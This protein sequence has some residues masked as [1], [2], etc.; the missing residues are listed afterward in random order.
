L[1]G[2]IFEPEAGMALERTL[3]AA[4]DAMLAAGEVEAVRS[5]HDRLAEIGGSGDVQRSFD[6]AAALVAAGE[7]ERAW[8]ELERLGGDL[9]DS[10]LLELHRRRAD[11]A[12]ARGDDAESTAQLRRA[13]ELAEKS[14]DRA[15][16]AQLELRLSLADFSAGDEATASRH[17]VSALSNWQQAGAFDPL[18][19]MVEEL[20]G[21]TST[22]SRGWTAALAAIRD[23]VRELDDR[24]E[25]LHF[26]L[27]DRSTI[28]RE[29][30]S[31]AALELQPLDAR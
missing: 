22:R 7:P 8:E 15:A 10:V 29:L 2:S 19:V 24:G 12:F 1:V 6:V 11:I 13:L 16:V 26:T 25:L 3:L 4:R 30:E 28:E 31:I 21:L 14:G 27:T 23:V 17:M 18:L 20:R 5:L 9:D